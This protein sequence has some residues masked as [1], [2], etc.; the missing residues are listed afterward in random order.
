M[1]Q[2][3]TC[4]ACDG[5]TIPTPRDPS[6]S[7]TLRLRKPMPSAK[8]RLPHHARL[9]QQVDPAI[10]RELRA[11]WEGRSPWPVFLHGPAGTGKTSIG[12]VA[13]DATRG[14]YLTAAQLCEQMRRAMLGEL[15]DYGTHGESRITQDDLWRPW[16]DADLAVLDELGA[17]ERVSD[18]GYDT[19]KRALD[20]RDGRPLIAISNIGPREIR[21]IYDDRI[22][23]RLCRGTVIDVVGPDRRLCRRET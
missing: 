6:V 14:I 15:V 9:A 4:R 18:F 10:R 16:A 3:E 2:E 21:A 22:V 20:E 19:I 12:L 17:R 23:S 8:R 1:S 13:L 11:V 7:T 5:M